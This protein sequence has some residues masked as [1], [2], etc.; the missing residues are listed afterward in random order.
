[1]NYIHPIECFYIVYNKF[2][3]ITVVMLRISWRHL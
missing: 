2:N 1:M 3:I